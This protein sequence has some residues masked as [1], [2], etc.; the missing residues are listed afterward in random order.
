M[1]NPK[2]HHFGAAKRI[3]VQDRLTGFDGGCRTAETQV[4]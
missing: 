3:K 1:Q 2:N 4:A